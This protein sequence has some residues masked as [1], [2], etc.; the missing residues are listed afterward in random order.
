LGKYLI[1]TNILL[2]I[3]LRQ[4]KS[5]ICKNFLDDHEDH[6]LCISDFTL[7]SI[8]LIL[9]NRKDYEGYNIFADYFLPKLKI[10][11]LRKNI[12]DVFGHT[13][14]FTKLDYDD[15]YQYWVAV[16]EGLTLV[17]L[18]SDFKKVSKDIP[19]VFL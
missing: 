4:E 18:D 1:D 14:K 10:K 3:L 11:S 9:L 5:S 17:T 7:H 2:E 6:E 13:F 8:G 12:F 19:V 16:E 15:F